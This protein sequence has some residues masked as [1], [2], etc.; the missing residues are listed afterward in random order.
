MQAKQK[1]PSKLTKITKITANRKL[2]KIL[3]TKTVEDNL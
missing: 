2:K 3:N 1:G